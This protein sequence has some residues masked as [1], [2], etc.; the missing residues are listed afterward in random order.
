[1]RGI[2]ENQMLE[3]AQNASPLGGTLRRK[4]ALR[5]NAIKSRCNNANNP[6]YKYYGGKGVKC[7]LTTDKLIFLWERDMA[8]LMKKP[9]IHRIDSNK[10]YEL[11]NCKFVEGNYNS[12]LGAR[13]KNPKNFMVDI[14]G[15]E[16]NLKEKIYI[17]SSL[18]EKPIKDIIKKIIT[19]YLKN[20]EYMK[21]FNF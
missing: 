17:I 14:G 6:L 8:D 12:G 5:L 2:Q 18:T 7:N 4:L 9:S 1:M 16:K 13:H 11:E 15:I 21:N 19:D 10:S 3:S 20:K